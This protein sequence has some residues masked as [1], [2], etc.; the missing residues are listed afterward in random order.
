[1]NKAPYSNG[2]AERS[3]STSGVEAPGTASRKSKN[4]S[5]S[6][7][8]ED[9]G[10]PR[11]RNTKTSKEP[12]SK[13]K[14]SRRISVD[15]RRSGVEDEGSVL[16]SSDGEV[17]DHVHDPQNRTRARRRG[18][19][20]PGCS[21]TSVEFLSPPPPAKRT[22]SRVS[23]ADDVEEAKVFA[24]DIPAHDVDLSSDTEVLPKR[25]PSVEQDRK[26][27]S[28]YGLDRNGWLDHDR[29]SSA[30]QPVS[31]AAPSVGQKSTSS[32]GTKDSSTVRRAG[33]VTEQ[34]W[35]ELNREQL[36][37]EEHQ[38]NMKINATDHHLELHQ[39]G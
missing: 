7:R 31:C 4:S 30:D 9:V 22:T 20:S 28:L 34:S 32:T 11:H 39:A 25:Q 33:R 6:S 16:A 24:A 36:D 21:S 35:G 17:L 12:R 5:S 1:G 18:S 8:R 27:I 29:R 13:G 3:R 15:G 38:K 2:K 14:D 26:R 37:A 23:F 10:R 19:S